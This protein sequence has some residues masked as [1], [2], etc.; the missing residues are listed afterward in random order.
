MCL[1]MACGAAILSSGTAAQTEIPKTRRPAQ[2]QEAASETSKRPASVQDTARLAVEK[3]KAASIPQRPPGPALITGLQV[4]PSQRDTKLNL[5]ADKK[6]EATVFTLASPYRVIVDLP[7]LNF[8]LP[9]SAARQNTG[10]IKAI[11]FGLMAPGRARLVME[12]VGPVSVSHAIEPV[13]SGSVAHRLAITLTPTTADEFIENM[14]PE[15]AEPST[16]Q[17]PPEQKRPSD[18]PVVMIDPGHGG[19]DG[20]ATGADQTL[21][22]DIV[23]AVALEL[24]KRLVASGRYDVRMTRADDRFLSLDQRVNLSQTSGAN[25]FLSVHADAVPDNVLA[26]SVHGA[27]V[28]TLSERASNQAAQ[29]L[30]DK[31]NAADSNAGVTP[32]SVGNE[33]IDLILSDLVARETRNFSLK[34][35]SLLTSRLTAQ[36]LAARDPARAAAFRVLRQ[37][38]TPSVLVELGFMTNA[39]EVRQMRSEAWQA[40]VARSLATAVDAFFGETRR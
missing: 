23:L 28:Y 37:P 4:V 36:K 7:D 21:E 38:Q 39:E 8:A 10:Q 13:S 17:S 15:P 18:K 27:T 32:V 30:A 33:Q 25:L 1:V 3:E 14:R 2:V 11:R 34:F 24:Q 31:E 9:Q 35:R 16:V 29:R 19:I 12:T 40:R 26:G 5:N 20:G 22:K 6:F